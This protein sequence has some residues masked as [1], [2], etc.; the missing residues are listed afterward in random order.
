MYRFRLLLLLMIGLFTVSITLAEPTAQLRLDQIN[1]PE[2]F[3]I[4]IFSNDVRGAR[5]YGAW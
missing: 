3:R 2:G 5:F 1:L 4:D